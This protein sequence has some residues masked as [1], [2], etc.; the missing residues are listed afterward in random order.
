MERLITAKQVLDVTGYRS[1]T[2][3][4]RTVR[5]RL[6]PAPVKL[7]DAAIRWREAEVLEWIE[8]APR[9]TYGDSE[10]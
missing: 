4:W 7:S 3:L 9:Q 8:E 10:A 6:F 5:A 2:T 1:R